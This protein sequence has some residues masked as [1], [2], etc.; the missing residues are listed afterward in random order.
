VLISSYVLLFYC[1][2]H[3]GDVCMLPL[4]LNMHTQEDRHQ[5][6]KLSLPHIHFSST[7]TFENIYN[8]NINS[9]H[10]VAHANKNDLFSNEIHR[11]TT[12]HAIANH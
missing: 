2:T 7:F 1:I 3:D 4:E 8:N 12:R 11:D 5:E 9:T 10:N 6:E